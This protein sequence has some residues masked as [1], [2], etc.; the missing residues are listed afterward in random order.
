M[1]ILSIMGLMAEG[2]NQINELPVF[3]VCRFIQG[4]LA[5]LYLALVP[6]YVR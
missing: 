4:I 3:F 6:V 2:S 1:L 5:G